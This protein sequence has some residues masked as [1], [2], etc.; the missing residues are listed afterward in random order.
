MTASF[1]L[2]LFA[3]LVVGLNFA[4]IFLVLIGLIGGRPQL[5]DAPIEIGLLVVSAIGW[6][7]VGENHRR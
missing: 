5:L 7:L 4:L 2:K 1:A 6:H 3:Q